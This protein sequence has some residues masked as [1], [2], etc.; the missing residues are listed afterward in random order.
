MFARSNILKALTVRNC[1]KRRSQLKEVK[2]GVSQIQML[3]PESCIAVVDIRPARRANAS[4]GQTPT[5][6]GRHRAPPSGRLP[7]SPCLGGQHSGKRADQHPE[8]SGAISGRPSRYRRFMSPTILTRVL[9]STYLV[10]MSAGF[11]E[12]ST[13]WRETAPEQAFS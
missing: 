2:V 13:L 4:Q 10:I 6:S 1:L 9:A 3:R 11:S 12:P 7:R 8:A 5:W